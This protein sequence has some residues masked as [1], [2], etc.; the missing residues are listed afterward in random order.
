MKHSRLGGSLASNCCP[1]CL[2]NPGRQP[3]GEFDGV[4]QVSGA[5]KGHEPGGPWGDWELVDTTKA[6]GV[7]SI[8]GYAGQTTRRCR[9]R[10]SRGASQCRALALATAGD[11]QCMYFRLHSRSRQGALS[12]PAQLL[13]AQWRKLTRLPVSGVAQSARTAERDVSGAEGEPRLQR[14]VADR[15]VLSERTQGL[16]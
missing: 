1:K 6:S 15:P 9:E 5:F 2:R 14:S 11:G 7:A 12:A 13:H 10:S 8:R 16:Y 3:D 4:E